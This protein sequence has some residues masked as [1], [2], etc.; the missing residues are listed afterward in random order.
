MTHLYEQPPKKAV[1]D[2]DPQFDARPL[3]LIVCALFFPIIRVNN[4]SVPFA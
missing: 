4:P 1:R 2:G 3:L